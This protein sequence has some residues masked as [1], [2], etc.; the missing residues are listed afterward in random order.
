MLSQD[1][2]FFTPNNNKINAYFKINLELKNVLF[3]EK[4]PDLSFNDLK[5]LNDYRS[6]DEGCIYYKHKLTNN[7]YSWNYMIKKWI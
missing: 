4:Y 1:N 7:I 6:T 2:I 5:K 3:D